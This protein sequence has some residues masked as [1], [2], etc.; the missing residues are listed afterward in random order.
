MEEQSGSYFSTPNE[1]DLNETAPLR[2]ANAGAWS[3]AEDERLRVAIAKHGTRWTSVA[4]DVATRNG[5]QC[6]KRWTDYVNPL[7]NHGP[8]SAD[9]DKTLM[10]LVTVHGH[11]WKLMADTHHKSRSPLSLKN[12]YALL[13]RRQRR[14]HNKRLQASSDSNTLP[15]DC[16]PA[17]LSLTK[18]YHIP[19]TGSIHIDVPTS[20]ESLGHTDPVYH[21]SDYALPPSLP[22]SRTALLSGYED[23]L[24]GQDRFNEMMEQPRRSALRETHA[25]EG[26]FAESSGPRH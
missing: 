17:M 18:G 8:W 11:N 4:A 3:G 25:L 24:V 26:R 9:E 2:T 14:H 15:R 16:P 23:Q 12:R 10:D 1:T 6:A 7:L 21:V 20:H 19:Q 22:P 13:A 5:E